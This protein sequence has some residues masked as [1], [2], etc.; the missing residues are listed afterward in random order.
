[1]KI[2][3]ERWNAAVDLIYDRRRTGFDPLQHY[4]GLFGDKNEAVGEKKVIANLPVEE[5]LKQRIIDGERIGIEKDLDEAMAKYPPLDIINT[6]LL[7]VMKV[8]GEL[9]GAGKMQ[10]P[11]VLSSAETMKAAVAHLEPHME[12]VGGRSK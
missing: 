1:N 4:L 11:F 5:R 7:D 6:F 3:D 9:F 10:L 8:V 2:S 12:K